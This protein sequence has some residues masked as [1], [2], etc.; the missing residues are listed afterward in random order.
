MNKTPLV[1]A[2]AVA[3]ALASLPAAAQAPWTAPI[4]VPEPSFGVRETPPAYDPANPLHLYVNGLAPCGDANNGGRGSPSAPRCTIPQALPAG[5]RVAVEGLSANSTVVAS[6][7]SEAPVWIIGTGAALVRPAQVGIYLLVRGSS[8][9]VVDGLVF[10]GT[11][12]PDH[13]PSSAWA[14]SASHHA[15]VRNSIVKNMVKPPYDPN[16]F[17]S[18]EAGCLA[19][20]AGAWYSALNSVTAGGGHTHDIVIYKNDISNNAGGQFLDYENGRHGIIIVGDDSA[21]GQTLER[22]WVL[23]NVIHNN[24]ENGIQIGWTSSLS[25]PKKTRFIYVARNRITNNG[26]IALGLKSSDHIVIS[27]NAMGGYRATNHTATRP[28]AVSGSDGSAVVISDD[29]FGPDHTWTMFN[30]IYDSRVG[31]RNVAGVSGADYPLHEP[32]EHFIVGNLIASIHKGPDEPEPTTGGL[33]GGVGYYHNNQTGSSYVIGN[34]FSGVNGG[35]FE[36]GGRN[37]AVLNNIV[38]GLAD[39][40]QGWPLLTRNIM[41]TKTFSS[42]IYFDPE[43]PIRR[44]P[45]V[46]SLDKPDVDPMLLDPAAGDFRPRPGS[47]AIDAG[48]DLKALADAYSAQHGADIMKDLTGAARPQGGGWEIGAFEQPPAVD[49]SSPTPPSAWRAPIGIPEPAFGAREQAPAYDSTNALHFWVDNRPGC[50]DTA[51]GGRGSPALPRCAIPSTLEAGSLVELR[52]GPYVGDRTWTM[53]GTQARP[54]FVRGG[55]AQSRPALHDGQLTLR[56]AYFVVEHLELS[57]PGSRRTKIQIDPGSHH[58][59]V[60]HNF[61]HDAPSTTG[62]GIANLGDDVVVLG[63]EVSRMGPFGTSSTLDVHGVWTGCET[64]RVWIVDNHIHHNNGDAIQFGHG[65]WSTANGAS[66]V[67]IGRNLLHDD[68]ENAVDIKQTSGTVIISQNEMFGYQATATSSGEALRINDEGEQQDVWI[69]F[70]RVHDS[71]TCI[72]PE[73]SNSKAVFI[74]GN[75]VHGCGRGITTL[76]QVGGQKVTAVHNTVYNA[77]T[78]IVGDRSERPDVTAN[79]VSSAGAAITPSVALCSRNLF[80]AAPI[81]AGVA[82]SGT[83]SSDPLLT[84]AGGGAPAGLRAGSPAI[85][86]AGA[87]HP[88]YGLFQAR[89]GL[90][91]RRDFAGNSRPQGAGWDIGAFEAASSTSADTTPPSVAIT[92]PAEAA[93]ISGISTMSATASD[94]VG[95]TLV[96]FLIDGVVFASFTAP[97]F[98]ISGDS[99]L[100]PDGPRRLT[101]RALDAAG[102]VSAASITVTYANSPVVPPAPTVPAAPR[103]FRR[104]S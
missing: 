81:Q 80:H 55:G 50:S 95:V 43:G 52:G 88:V 8:Y 63:N 51:N 48:V 73:N 92:A 4:G 87:E 2:A 45:M 49:V 56:G 104:S 23:D 1:A 78:G 84:L 79:L 67:Y 90:D 69:L 77:T 25:D 47:P 85:D 86:A 89:F 12:T 94:D 68:R 93:F 46:T 74:V 17:S 59:A 27:Q 83:V 41:G 98:T 33:N 40:A 32:G 20:G 37:V 61:L 36:A 13:S 30:L 96:E 102:N 31:I 16:R 26:E 71:A 99:R 54:V 29:G 22:V 58:A 82:C 19:G 57:Q 38:L 70:N 62:S 7:T 44:D 53:N 39:H 103:R 97:P 15:A 35:I 11:G 18:H 3:A 28:C 66:Q 24:P 21:A 64:K 6:G 14:V 9:V 5:S 100:V 60:R 34:T 91:I 76:Q 10:D 65:C 75:V 72:N 42:N 101:V